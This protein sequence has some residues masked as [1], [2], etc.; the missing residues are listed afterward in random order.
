MLPARYEVR[1]IRAGLKAGAHGYL[2]KPSGQYKLL[3]LTKTLLRRSNQHSTNNPAS[4]ISVLCIY[5]DL[6]ISHEMGI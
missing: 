1:T 2:T 4:Q 3:A 5:K 6:S